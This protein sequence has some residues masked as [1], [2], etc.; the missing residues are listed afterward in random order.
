MDVKGASLGSKVAYITKYALTRGVYSVQLDENSEIRGYK[1][2]EYLT[3]REKS[4]RYQFYYTG[5]WYMNEQDA[6]CR[7]EEM[8]AKKVASLERQLEKL[9]AM[10]F[11][12]NNN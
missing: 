2:G 6:L 10:Q 7:A 8:R 5:Q 3:I 12:I 11:V 1:G 4:Y 9:K